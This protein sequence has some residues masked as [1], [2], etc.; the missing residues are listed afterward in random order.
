MFESKFV[1]KIQTHCIIVDRCF[2]IHVLYGIMWKNIVEPYNIIGRMRIVCWM[3]KATNTNS[4]C[5]L[6]IAF[7]PRHWLH[8][9][10]SVLTF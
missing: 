9:R 8:E 6:L 5:V 3:L 7:P 10:A 2:E 1:E 4:E